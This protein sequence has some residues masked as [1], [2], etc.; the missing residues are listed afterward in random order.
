MWELSELSEGEGKVVVGLDGPARAFGAADRASGRDEA[1]TIVP[2]AELETD[3]GDA[4]D[5][6]TEDDTS[7][8]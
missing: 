8:L 1:V 7:S 5:V 2:G 6:P 3:E 4:V